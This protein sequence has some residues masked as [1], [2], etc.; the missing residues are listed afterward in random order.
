MGVPVE[1]LEAARGAWNELM[2]DTLQVE[3][4]AHTE[5]GEGG[6]TS[7]PT[8]G[9]SV[10]AR[11]APLGG[12]RSGSPEQV[13]AARLG[14]LEGWVV[15]VPVGTVINEKDTVLIGGVRRLQVTSVLAPRSYDQ[16]TRVLCQEIE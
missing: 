11:V 9:P 4:Y 12:G 15:T 7:A 6:W 3:H 13:I 10:A 16:A 1:E 14:L 8:L 5:D 2:P